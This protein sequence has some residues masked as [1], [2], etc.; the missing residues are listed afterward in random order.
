MEL[1]KNV[2]IIGGQII[3]TQV[4][5]YKRLLINKLKSFFKM[6]TLYFLQTFFKGQILNFNSTKSTDS[7]KID[8]NQIDSFYQTHNW[9]F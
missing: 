2:T 6:S 3:T 5:S 4:N 1:I 7:V 9:H 8:T